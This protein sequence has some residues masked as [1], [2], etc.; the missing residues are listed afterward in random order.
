MRISNCAG[1]S[2]TLFPAGKLEFT[3]DLESTKMEGESSH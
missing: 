3:N 2:E 1:F